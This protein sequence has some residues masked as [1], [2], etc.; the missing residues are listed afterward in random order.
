MVEKQP[1]AAKCNV[2]SRLYLLTQQARKPGFQEGSRGCASLGWKN[3]SCWG[4]AGE[5]GSQRVEFSW[6]GDI[7]DDLIRV[8]VRTAGSHLPFF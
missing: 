3:N 2:L 5:R 7:E 4:Q 1:Q 6:T 8:W